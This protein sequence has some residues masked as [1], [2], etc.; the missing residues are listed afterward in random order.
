MNNI[1]SPFKTIQRIFLNKEKTAKG[2]DRKVIEKNYSG[3]TLS[4]KM[5]L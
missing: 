2:E 5:F 1:P 3:L 4:K